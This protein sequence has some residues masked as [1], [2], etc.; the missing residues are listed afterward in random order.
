MTVNVMPQLVSEHRF[1]LIGRIVI[2]QSVCK[3]NSTSCSETGERSVRLLTFFGKMPLINPTHTRACTLS[4]PRKPLLKIL[5]VERF[6]FIKN[7]EENYRRNLRKQHEES[8]KDS[9]CNQPPMFRRL[10]NDEIQNFN[11]DRCQY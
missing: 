8:Q 4:K 6:E 1:D 3:N 5:V 9:P 11:H 2:E 10:P 7:R